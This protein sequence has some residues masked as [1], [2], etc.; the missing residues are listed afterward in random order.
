MNQVAK[1]GTGA[2]LYLFFN[3]HPVYVSRI[4]FIATTQF[5]SLVVLGMMKLMMPFLGSASLSSITVVFALGPIMQ[6]RVNTL[7]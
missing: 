7:S 2:S 5:L 3:E 4:N 6:C 1:S